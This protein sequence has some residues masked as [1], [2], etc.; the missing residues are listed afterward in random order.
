MPGCVYHRTALNDVARTEHLT[1]I[2]TSKKEDAGPNNNWMAP[3][4]AYEKAGSYF[5]DSMAGRT[6][7]VI[8]FSMGPV[9]SEFSA[10]LA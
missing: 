8:P 3:K 10:R 9:G 6:M 5:K 2:C 7:Y 4:E 1:Y